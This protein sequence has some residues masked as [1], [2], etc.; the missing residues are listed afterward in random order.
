MEQFNRLSPIIPE[1]IDTSVF[2]DFIAANQ[3]V[4]DLPTEIKICLEHR[5]LSLFTYSPYLYDL[6]LQY[7]Q[8]F[9][10]SC[11][12][13]LPSMVE[14]IL[15]PL[16][17][18]ITMPLDIGMRDLRIAKKQ[19][20]LLTAIAD[21]FCNFELL[22]VTA[23]LSRFA[24]IALEVSLQHCLNAARQKGDIATTDNSAGLFIIAMGKLGA[25]E[26]NYSSDIDLIVFYDSEKTHYRGRS[27]IEDMFVNITRKIV[28]ILQ[29]RT[30]DGYVFRVDLQLRP[31]PG[32]T[33]V[34][35]SI[36]M[37]EYYY[38]S[39]GQNW[40]RSAFIKARPAAGDIE[41][42][43][44]FLQQLRPFIW[45]RHLDFSTVRDIRHMKQMVMEHHGYT[46][47]SVEGQNVKLGRGGIRDIEFFVQL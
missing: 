47:I 19:I 38:Q 39:V 13:P 16:D 43:Q 7:P 45:R 5:L 17:Q 8:L 1:V 34:A 4:N 11:I 23:I 20:A 24:D 35:V 28:K 37:A 44:Q 10:K 26:L 30:V 41:G 42:G 2:A 15:S 14:A 36:I 18:L 32:S 33:P 40:E 31:D 9:I 21:L 29:D 22:E 46:S 3:M 27:S 6:C 12:D 25:A